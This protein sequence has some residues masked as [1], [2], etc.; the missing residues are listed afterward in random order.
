MTVLANEYFDSARRDNIKLGRKS[1]CF[2]IA[3]RLIEKSIELVCWTSDYIQDQPALSMADP[4]VSGMC[5]HNC[6]T[7]EDF[8]IGKESLNEEYG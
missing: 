2:L 6:E 3:L 7:M 4:V 1:N 8:E 5:S